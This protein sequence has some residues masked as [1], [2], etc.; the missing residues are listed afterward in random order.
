MGL[1][2]FASYQIAAATASGNQVLSTPV[3]GNTIRAAV[4][5]IIGDT[6]LGTTAQNHLR[7]GVGMT[8]GTTTKCLSTRSR[9]N[10]TTSDAGCRAATGDIIDFINA[11]NNNA[12]GVASFVSF[13]TDQLTINWS[14]PPGAAFYMDVT[15]F[16]GDL[17]QAAVRQHAS[18]STNGGTNSISGIGF[19]PNMAHVYGADRGFPNPGTGVNHG[20][21]MHGLAVDNDGTTEQGC[22]CYYERDNLS[23][24][25]GIGPIFRDDAIL[26]DIT[27][28]ALGNATFNQRVRVDSWD[29]GG[30]TVETLGGS[31]AITAAYLL[32][33][34]SQNR[35]TLSFQDLET[36]TTGTGAAK[37][38]TTG[39]KP[40]TGRIV[41]TGL[42]L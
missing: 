29:S 21:L 30:I 5:E 1:A 41:G 20:R 38:I 32:L 16:F 9:D 40:A 37:K 15:V 10:R 31:G 33:D 24:Q 14:N 17:L 4:I 28:N 27:M 3:G 7:Y 6:S 42:N 19:Q 11:G 12:N 23:I 18:S 34:V 36:A 25:S 39:W 13:G 8:D 35:R 22:F 2:G 26:Q